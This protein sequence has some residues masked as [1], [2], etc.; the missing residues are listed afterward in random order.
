MKASADT[1]A[2][3]VELAVAL[4]LLL[5]LLFG[6]AE[7]GRFVVASNALNTATR[8]AARYGSSVGDSVNS[9][10]RYT[11]CDEI[12]AV[13]SRFD[14]SISPADVTI[15]FDSGPGTVQT[16]VCPVGGPSIDPNL[17]QAGDRIEVY[18][19]KN[20]SFVVPIVGD[21]IEAGAGGPIAIRSTGIRSIFK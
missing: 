20:F 17:I 4:P 8:E 16:A 3:A 14:S 2:T 21:L 15:I 7:L 12:R 1:G 9:V 6:I 5:V 10:P 18:A 11:D 13:A 19:Q